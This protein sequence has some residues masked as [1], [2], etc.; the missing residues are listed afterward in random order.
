MAGHGTPLFFLTDVLIAIPGI[1]LFAVNRFI[2]KTNQHHLTVETN[3]K[4]GI[5][6]I[7]TLRQT[8]NRLNAHRLKRRFSYRNPLSFELTGSDKL[9][10]VHCSRPES[11]NR[12]QSN[13]MYPMEQ[14]VWP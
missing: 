7:S 13:L 4:H 6:I 2:Y 11:S 3:R 5:L 1:E 12:L 8:I 9:I 10:K 14:S